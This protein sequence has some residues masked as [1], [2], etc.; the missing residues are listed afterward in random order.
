MYIFYINYSM[1]SKKVKFPFFIIISVV[2]FSRK[3][4]IDV[5]LFDCRDDDKIDPKNCS[6]NIM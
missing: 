4:T 2:V 6:E 3:L 5:K 1:Q